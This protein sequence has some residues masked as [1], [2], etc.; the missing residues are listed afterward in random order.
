MLQLFRKLTLAMSYPRNVLKM[1][2]MNSMT[3]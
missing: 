1:E 2:L 3:M